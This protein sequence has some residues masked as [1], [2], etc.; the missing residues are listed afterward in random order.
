MER[1][2]ELAIGVPG[3]RV[4]AIPG[5]FHIVIRVPE[6]A[7]G[8]LGLVRRIVKGIKPA[9]VTDTLEVSSA[10][11]SSAEVSSVEGEVASP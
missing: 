3:F 6:A 11:V 4:E 5:A 2:L 8:Q 10:E 9:H 7:A 1:F